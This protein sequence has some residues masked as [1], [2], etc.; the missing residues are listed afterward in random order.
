MIRPGRFQAFCSPRRSVPVRPHQ[1]PRRL[2]RYD[3]AGHLL[4]G[5]NFFAPK[6]VQADFAVW[7]RSW[8]SCE[9][10]L[11]E[12]PEDGSSAW[13]ELAGIHE[14]RM[15]DAAVNPGRYTRK[16]IF[17]CCERIAAMLR[18]ERCRPADPAGLPAD[19]IIMSLPYLLLL[20]K[21]SALCGQ[22]VA[23]QFR[24]E[25][26]RHEGGMPHARTV[27]RSAVHR[28]A[29]AHADAEGGLHVAAR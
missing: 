25:V 13:L 2:R 9:N 15:S 16:T 14:R 3:P 5:W 10:D 18:D 19:M 28:V 27:F 29:P 7:Y 1:R 17:T 4:P 26:V 22:A 8:E 12:V 20:T 23:V 11:G 24:I 21:V 6:P